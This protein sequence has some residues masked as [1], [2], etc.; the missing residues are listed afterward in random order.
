M[1]EAVHDHG[2]R[3]DGPL[4]DIGDVVDEQDLFAADIEAVRGVAV[5]GVM[6][7]LLDRGLVKISGR[8]EVPGRPL[9]YQTTEY[10]LQHFGLKTVDDLPN[11]S[12]L[13]RVALPVATRSTADARP[14]PISSVGKE[15][16]ITE[17]VAGDSITDS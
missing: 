1:R 9:L 13:K 15:T 7:V 14:F 17:A 4:G 11:S 5:D 10:F 16:S 3:F 8:A 2:V 12:E 6:Q